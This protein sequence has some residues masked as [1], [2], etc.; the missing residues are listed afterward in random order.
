MLHPFGKKYQSFPAFGKLTEWN[1]DVAPVVM[2]FFSDTLGQIKSRR[3]AC[4]VTGHLKTVTYENKARRMAP[5]GAY[6]NGKEPL[7]CP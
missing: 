2:Y 7:L 4:A 1:G 6:G 5:F 3:G